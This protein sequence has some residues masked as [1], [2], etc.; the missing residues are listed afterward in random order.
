M[1]H[2]KIAPLTVALSLM[3]SCAMS[4]DTPPPSTPGLTQEQ[5]KKLSELADRFNNKLYREPN[6]PPGLVV[7]APS[8]PGD[9]QSQANLALLLKRLATFEAEVEELRR[10]VSNLY[11]EKERL[12]IELKAEKVRTEALEAALRALA[13]KP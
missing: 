5:I 1:R 3:M 8:R 9:E 10:V 11:A 12:Q 13:P 7:V 6:S 2:R 4:A